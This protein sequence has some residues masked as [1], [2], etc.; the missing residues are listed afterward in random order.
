M[1][2]RLRHGSAHPGRDGKVR[3]IADVPGILEVG[4]GARLG[5][6]WEP[7]GR[8][9]GPFE[10]VRQQVADGGRQYA[11]AGIGLRRGGFQKRPGRV[12]DLEHIHR[13][14]AMATVGKGTVGGE[15]V[16]HAQF[17]RA[18][19]RR[20]AGIEGGADPKAPRSGEDLLDADVLEQVDR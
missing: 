8:V 20:Q 6:D 5:R 9:D 18:E 2:R 3:C 17:T 15:M 4:G 14:N 19:R 13:P 12:A 7:H 11:L 10:N 16:D 1:R